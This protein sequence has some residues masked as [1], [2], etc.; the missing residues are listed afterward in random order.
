MNNILIVEDDKSILENLNSLLKSEGYSVLTASGQ[1]EAENILSQNEVDLILLD[2]TLKDGNGFSF[3]RQIKEN[4]PNIPIIFL[5]ALDDESSLI[6]GL[7]LGADDYIS[8]P[9]RSGELLARLHRRLQKKSGISKMKIQNLIVNFDTAQVLKQGKEINLSALEY[10]IFLLLIRRPGIILSREQLLSEIWDFG[11]DF[12]N[13]N[14]LTV[15]IKRLR[16]KLE[17]DPKEPK[18]IVTV[19]GIGYKVIK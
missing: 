8:K 4:T 15:Y 19:R 10:K 6:T 3:C 12:V 13:D 9:F 5:T 17:D 11:G 14:T 16:E 2:V 1:R 7:S 18:I